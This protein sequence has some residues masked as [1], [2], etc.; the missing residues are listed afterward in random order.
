VVIID[1]SA[2]ASREPHLRSYRACQESYIYVS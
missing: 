2:V 1:M